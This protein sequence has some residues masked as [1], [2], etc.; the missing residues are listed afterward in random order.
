ML[1]FGIV[2]GEMEI[3]MKEYHKKHSE[4]IFEIVSI[5]EKYQLTS[6]EFEEELFCVL[7]LLRETKKTIEELNEKFSN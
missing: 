7:G 3:K 1:R 5:A 6:Y 2:I 4:I